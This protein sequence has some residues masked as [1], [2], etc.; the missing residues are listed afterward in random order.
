VY[1]GGGGG[2]QGAAS[3]GARPAPNWGKRIKWTAITLVTLLIVVSVSTY[4]WADSKLKREVD[5]SKVIDRPSEGEGTNYLIVGSDSR[6]GVTAEEKKQLHTGSAEGKRTD[7]MM[8]L[9]VGGNGD[10]LISLPRDSDVEIP[11]CGRSD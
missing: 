9:H 8:I 6:A 4:F 10:T 7:S 1:G 5:L 3:R 11:T 2:G